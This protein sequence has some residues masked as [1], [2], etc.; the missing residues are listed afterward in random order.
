MRNTVSTIF[1]V[2]VGFALPIFAVPSV[3]YIG[4]ARKAHLD[5]DTQRGEVLFFTADW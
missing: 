4:D 5:I 3:R 2:V 1:M